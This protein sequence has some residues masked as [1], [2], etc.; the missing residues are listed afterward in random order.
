MADALAKPTQWHRCTVDQLG[1]VFHKQREQKLDHIVP[2]D[3]T[4]RDD[5]VVRRVT[6]ALPHSPRVYVA[7]DADPEDVARGRASYQWPGPP[8]GR[9][10][11][12]MLRASQR[13]ACM[14]D[15]GTADVSVIIEYLEV[16]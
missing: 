10:I 8:S 5:E 2:P 14:A 13:I 15:E 4:I 7:I 9:T 3:K 6:I 12:L 1:Q 11:C 16:R